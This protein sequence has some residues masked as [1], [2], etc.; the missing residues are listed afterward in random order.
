M[1]ALLTHHLHFG[2][3]A[4]TKQGDLHAAHAD[5]PAY[6]FDSSAG[7]R[8]VF[9]RF[10]GTGNPFEAMQG[11]AG[12]H[13]AR[14]RVWPAACRRLEEA[15]CLHRIAA[16]ARASAGQAPSNLCAA[17]SLAALSQRFEALTAPKKP[18]AGKPIVVSRARVGLVSVPGARH[19]NQAPG[20]PCCPR[21][22]RSMTW[23]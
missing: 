16:A 22:P 2:A 21:P 15:R 14:I 6:H 20:P 19:Q 1:A 12:T 17:C 23:S 8:A 5:I 3:A 9:A 11:A 4:A 13:A 7:S 18:E 10:F